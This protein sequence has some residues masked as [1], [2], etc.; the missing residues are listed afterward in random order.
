[1]RD[2]QKY[3][4]RNLLMGAYVDRSQ[5]EVLQGQAEHVVYSIPF[6]TTPKASER[7]AGLKDAFS[8]F[9]RT[10]HQPLGS[11]GGTNFTAALVNAYE[12]IAA[13]EKSEGEVQRANILLITDGEDGVYSARVMQAKSKISK[14]AEIAFNVIAIGEGNAEL[15][16]MAEESTTGMTQSDSSKKAYHYIDYP[17]V[18]QLLHPELRLQKLKEISHDFR[19]EGDQALQS[20][21]R[22]LQQLKER[23]VRLQSENEGAKIASVRAQNEV[24]SWFTAGERIQ[25][26]RKGALNPYFQLFLKTVKHRTFSE[27]VKAEKIESFKNYI[28]FISKETQGLSQAV[29]LSQ[30]DPSIQ[31]QL[32]EW[33]D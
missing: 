6:D 14:A 10:R 23:F 2:Q 33:L 13:H 22:E 28:E 25:S 5:V 11:D 20:A 30:V 26:T 17:M 27:S 12:T 9:E 7:I 3:L 1:M 24:Q 4:L 32:R 18:N 16:Q 21:R 29:I 19:K 31:K 15:K 8:Y